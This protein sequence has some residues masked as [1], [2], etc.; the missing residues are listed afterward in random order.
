MIQWLTSQSS[1]HPCPASPV[2][3]NIGPYFSALVGKAYGNPPMTAEIFT[4]GL[5]YH[6]G[7]LQVNVHLRASHRTG[8]SSS[9]RP[10]PETWPL[11]SDYKA[12]P[13][14]PETLLLLIVSLDFSI[15]SCTHH[16]PACTVS[17]SNDLNQMQQYLLR[18]T[19]RVSTTSDWLGTLA[20]ISVQGHRATFNN[21]YSRAW[22]E[23]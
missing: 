4:N 7:A 21:L 23:K 17:S 18:N 15:P 22:A 16:H 11:Q 9:R 2:T 20:T 19:E 1:H 6:K 14:R 13:N 12:Y 3:P 8:A 10:C 5:Q